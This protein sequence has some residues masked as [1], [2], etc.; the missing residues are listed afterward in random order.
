MIQTGDHKEPAQVEPYAFKDEF[1]DLKFN[2]GHCG[3]G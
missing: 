3:Y 1:T 2:K